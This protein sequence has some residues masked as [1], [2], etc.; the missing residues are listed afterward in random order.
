M[1]EAAGKVETMLAAHFSVSM[2]HSRSE[3]AT[4]PLARTCRAVTP[5]EESW[6]M[7]LATIFTKPRMK[8]TMPDPITNLQK[9]VP[10]DFFACSLFVKVS[11]DIVSQDQHGDTKEIEPMCRAENRPYSGKVVFK[12]GAFRGDEKHARYSC[13]DMTCCIEEEEL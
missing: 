13:D 7:K 1:D 11:Q 9:E 8:T 4:A 12:Y 2:A 5:K 10:K 3:I 6:K